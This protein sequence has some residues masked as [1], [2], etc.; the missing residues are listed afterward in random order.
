MIDIGRSAG[1][2]PGSVLLPDRR[3]VGAG[4]HEHLFD[5]ELRGL[6]HAPGVHALAPHPVL[7]LGRGLEHGHAEPVARQRV[8]ASDAP[9]I[10]PPTMTTSAVSI[11]DPLLCRARAD[12]GAWHLPAPSA[13]WLRADH[14]AGLGIPGPGS[15]EPSRCGGGSSE[16]TL[17]SAITTGVIDE[18]R[19]HECHHAHRPRGGVHHPNKLRYALAAVAVPALLLLAFAIG[20]WTSN[21]A[22]SEPA[23][24][25]PGHHGRARRPERGRPVQRRP[26]LLSGRHATPRPAA[27]LAT[28]DGGSAAPSCETVEVGIRVESPTLIGREAELAELEQLLEVCVAGEAV[29]VVVGGDAGIGKTRLVE[30]LSRR[31]RERGAF[32]ATRRVRTVRRRRPA[33]RPRRRPGPGHAPQLA[34]RDEARLFEPAAGMLGVAGWD[35][36]DG[37]SVLAKT[38]LYESLLHACSMLAARSPLVLVVEDLQWSD[39]GSRELLD[40]LARNL[41]EA[42]VLVV[43][44][45]RTADLDSDPRLHR[46]MGEVGRH[47]HGSGLELDGLTRSDIAEIVATV[48]RSATD[49]E[50]IDEVWARSQGNPFYAEEL[51]AAGADAALPTGL[52][53]AIAVE[54]EALGDDARRLLAAAAV[55][56]Q[57]VSHDLLVAMEVLEDLALDRA[58]SELVDRHLLVV[59]RAGHGYRFRH[60]LLRETVEAGLL[61]GERRRL[62]RGRR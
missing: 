20:R 39:S 23:V 61:P 41:G 13:G 51:A 11:S 26:P 7:V 24:T 27:H 42:P 40:H 46:W 43:G 47:R 53:A 19:G 38:R 36:G 35:D 54:T 21:P 48:T 3:D 5:A 18:R 12:T 55:A 14:R 17:T 8:P 58:L 15:E 56:G 30:E 16:R 34:D 45:Y 4:V 62:N 50:L 33:L 52:Q 10:P 25:T 32:T 37:S 2:S 22:S 59:D 60:A 6:L 31:A 57:E 9:P 29:M 44:T 49:P 28:I 1:S